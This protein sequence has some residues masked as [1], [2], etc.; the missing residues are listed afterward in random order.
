MG[1]P[2]LDRDSAGPAAGDP[3]AAAQAGDAPVAAPPPRPRPVAPT[4]PEAAT[5]P[6]ASPSATPTPDSDART[7]LV[8]P[9]ADATLPAESAAAPAPC[10]PDRAGAGAGL[11]RRFGRY[12]LERELGRGG[13]GVVYRAWDADLQRAV[14]LKTLL[15]DAVATP[16]AVERFLREARAA[17]GL[18]HPHLVPVHDIGCT[19]G[20]HYFTMDFIEGETLAEAGERLPLRRFLEVLCLA[21][22]ALGAAHDAGVVHR[23]VKPGNLLLDREGRP[24]VSDFG[25]ATASAGASDRRMTATGA[26][27]GTPA[28]MSPEQAQGRVAEIGPR[29]DLWSIGVIL[30]ERL[31][32]R[33]P[34]SGGNAM[35]TLLAIVQREPRAPS[36]AAPATR[37]VHRDLDV[38]CLRCLEKAPERRYPSAG[39]LAEDLRRFLE[40]EPIKARPPSG[41]ERLRRWAARRPALVT[42]ASAAVLA[43]ALAGAA[44]R[45]ASTLDGQR[46]AA[47]AGRRQAEAEA[48]D[49][50]REIARVSLRAALETRRTG[51]PMF[52]LRAAFLDPLRRAAARAIERGPGLAEPHY[53]LG[54]LHRAMLDSAAARAEQERALAKQPDFAPSLYERAVLAGPE[55]RR[56]VEALRHDTRIAGAEAAVALPRPAVAPSPAAPAVVPEEIAERVRALHADLQRLESLLAQPAAAGSD[57]VGPAHLACARALSRAYTVADDRDSTEAEEALEAVLLTDP[58]LEEAYEGLI[59]L[60]AERIRRVTGHLALGAGADLEALR[61]LYDRAIGADRGY[62]PFWLGRG[63]V[64]SVLAGLAPARGE[65]RGA[66]FAPALDDLREAIRLDPEHPT[67]RVRLAEVTGACAIRQIDQ[68]DNPTKLV[69]AARAALAPL[70]ERPAPVAD[71]RIALASLLLQLGSWRYRRGEDP[72]PLAREARAQGELVARESPTAPLAWLVLGQACSKEGEWLAVRGEDPEPARRFALAALDRAALLGDPDERRRTLAERADLHSDRAI[73]CRALR[74]DL[75]PHLTAA[76]AD[77]DELVRLD[78]DWDLPRLLRARAQRSWGSWLLAEGRPGVG[79][80]FAA[81]AVEV[82]EAERLGPADYVNRLERGRLEYEQAM[83]MQE[84]GRDPRAHLAA[85][86]AAFERSETLA[87]ALAEVPAWRGLVRVQWGRWATT[88]GAA[89]QEQFAA[90]EADVSRALAINPRQVIALEARGLLAFGRRRWSDAVADLAA[91]LA[92][93]GPDRELQERLEESRARDRVAQLPEVAAALSLIERGRRAKL[94]ARLTQARDDFAAGL[95]RFEEAVAALA[96]GDRALLLPSGATGGVRGDLQEA[97]LALAGCLAV[98]SSGRETPMGPARA[99]PAEEVER[100]RAAAFAHLT[101][102]REWGWSDLAQWERDPGYAALRTDP[103]WRAALAGEV[104]LRR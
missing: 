73:W 32:G 44:T 42:A 69:E 8:S 100:L 36:R 68:G 37:P 49:T 48:V 93:G 80:R 72:L 63:T 35:E 79:E 18:R 38:I 13:M 70:L 28:Y 23:D 104:K 67:P 103:R 95:R 34:F 61:A 31:A 43:L 56:R 64:R 97:N 29:S 16:A 25:L 17:A 75:Q 88:R 33:L 50:L 102:A 24:Y 98:L 96:A 40:G 86:V 65:P 45:Q 3:A 71:A 14:A 27:L 81:A 94:M 78:P 2:A 22:R 10:G 15:P 1:D 59:Y 51:R 58:G 39:E 82:A 4:S 20:M 12:R 89:A 77:L 21:T 74:T 30:Y 47:E 11:P 5:L 53:H 91:A 62:A 52:D 6:A 84:R 99:L 41:A 9:P 60:V 19:D 92:A 7:R 57:L 85:A 54:R 83:W 76:L 55:L 87:P 46:R 90:A 66:D 26:L 101:A